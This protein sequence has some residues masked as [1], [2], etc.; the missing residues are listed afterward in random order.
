MVK[1]LSAKVTDEVYDKVN[2]MS[3]NHSEILRRAINEF[4]KKHSGNQEDTNNVA[5]YHKKT[6]G[7][8]FFSEDE[9]QRAREHVDRLKPRKKLKE[10]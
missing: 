9:Y 4:I 5:V 1:V 6:N 7:I 3:S 8:P 10:S 2:N